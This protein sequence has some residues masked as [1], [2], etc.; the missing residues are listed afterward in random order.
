MRTHPFPVRF[1]FALLVALSAIAAA[2]FSSSPAQAARGVLGSDVDHLA[3][4]VYPPE[5]VI[6]HQNRIG[7]TPDQRDEL[8]GEM[9]SAQSDLLPLQVE[10]SAAGERLARQLERPRVDEAGVVE[11]AGEMLAIE[12]QIKSRQLVLLLRIKNLL[13]EDQQR[14]L[15]RIRRIGRAMAEE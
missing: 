13:T 4:F 15:T 3:R 1:R 6:R 10:L 5:L 14:A 9:R 7:L 8:V 2:A 12:A 11:L